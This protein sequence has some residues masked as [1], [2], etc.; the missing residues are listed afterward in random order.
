MFSK[1]PFTAVPKKTSQTLKE[2][3]SFKIRYSGRPLPYSMTCQKRP[4]PFKLKLPCGSLMPVPLYCVLCKRNFVAQIIFDCNFATVKLYPYLRYSSRIQ[5]ISSFV[6]DLYPFLHLLV[7]IPK[8]FQTV[9]NPVS[10]SS[11][12]IA[13]MKVFKICD[14]HFRPSPLS[15]HLDI[16]R[17]PCEQGHFRLIIV[18][19][20]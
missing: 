12:M 10:V 14:V 4:S 9:W 7:E 20:V 18:C 6:C 19:D 1:L 8:T 17:N 15:L 13:S 5:R 3:T 11:H 16:I 2:P